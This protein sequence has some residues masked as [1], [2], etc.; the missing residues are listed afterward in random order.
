LVRSLGAIIVGIGS[1]RYDRVQ[2]PLL[3][4]ASNDADEVVQYLTTCWPK[5]D[6]AQLIRI[7]DEEATAEAV[8][9]AF[10]TLGQWGPYDLQLIF[11]SGHGLV[12]SQS[13]GFVVQPSA[14]SSS[15][16]VL[17]Y[18]RLDRL[19]AS[20]P[21]KRTILI[22]DCCYA[23][24]IT[25]RMTFFS[26]LGESDARLF[27]ASSREQQLTWEDEKTGHGI[28]TAHL[29]DL[30]NTGSS[31]K[32]KGV[33]D[34]LDVDG[35]LFPVLCDQVPLYVLEHKQQRQEPVKGGVSIRATTL[36]V[37][38]FA[39]RIKERTAFGTAVRRLRQIAV[40]TA[41]ACVAFLFFAYTLTYYAEADR[42]GDIRLHH[43]TKWLAPVFRFL[44]TLRA[45][46]GISVTDLS[47][48]PAT[49]Y[50]VQAGETSGFWTHISRQG[51]RAWYD[52]VRPSLGPAAAARYDVL[53]AVGA[54]RPVYRLNDG[55]RPSE[56]AFA[57]WALL[58][59]SDPGELKALLPHILGADQISPLLAQ[60]SANKMDFDI[61]DRP[62][63]ELASYADA[64]R[65]AAADD[66]DGT[67]VA[68]LGFL[69]ANQMWLA[70]SSPEQH[71]R[72]AQS[73]AADDVADVLAV[74]VKARV[75]RGETPLDPQM[76]SLLNQL[77]E[78]GYK[79]LVHVALS[80]VA[81]TPVDKRSEASQALSAFHG[82]SYDPAEAAAVRELKDSLDSSAASQAIVEETYRRFVAAGG[83][84]QTDLTAFLIAAADKKAIPPSVMTILLDKAREALARHDD[85]FIT[86]EHA[87]IL[88]H[89][90]GQVP[91]DSRQVAYRLIEMV[92]V[93]VTPLA[94]STAE[95][96]TAL[97]RQG[98]DT[99]AMFQQIVAQAS[100][101]V[102]YQPQ[103]PQLAAEPLPGLSIVVGH[104]PWLE[105]LAV[106]GAN[107]SLPPESIRVLEN[108]ANDPSVRDTIVRALAHQA[109]WLDQQC[110]KTSCSRM[111]GAFP[112]DGAKRQL[113]ADVLAEKLARLPR[114][115]FLVALEGLRKER[116]SET[117]AEVRI[118]LGLARIN[119]QLARVRTTPVGSQLFE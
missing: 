48:D 1:Y 95:M 53:L 54:M 104:G 80:R 13:A 58:D 27:V 106:L 44:P 21:A 24:G 8:T 43:G 96:Y 55:S 83:A 45:D 32:L 57:A 86:T 9:D 2:F 85:A 79:D 22:L 36:P 102:P 100:A 63:A 38:R 84:E 19:L 75:D 76:V 30:V 39:R 17:D 69:K 107:R 87:R 14:R 12:D 7:P 31:V 26:G 16:S 28:F 108:H 37:A 109:A 52:S 10:V 15:L 46:T 78:L 103:S 29:L 71:G 56:I 92:A 47:N 4:Y 35:E 25:R 34:R 91:V 23:E 115:E 62:Q 77:A 64:L 42:N 67:F 65:S 59:S 51:Y 116:A 3:K 60:F 18:A 40:G 72:E 5:P 111:L 20:V 101:A 94:S 88:A 89:A 61:L 93:T 99:P 74:I 49:R 110:W 50:A 105:A 6:D 66:P 117:E 90:M 114:A 82:N 81:A 73:R 70:H 97:G 119:A 33:R 118:A 11:L 112:E 98:L 68:Y 41:T 113:A